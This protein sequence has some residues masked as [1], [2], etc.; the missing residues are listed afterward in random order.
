MKQSQ[1]YMTQEFKKPVT[2]EGIIAALKT[3]EHIIIMDDPANNVYPMPILSTGH[4]EVYVGRIRMDDTVDSGC[5]L[6]VC[7]DN[8]RKG[9]ASNAVQIAEYMI[10]NNKI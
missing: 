10:K 9:A 2:K 1:E 6:W 4:D 3:Q 7:A 5:N 8:I